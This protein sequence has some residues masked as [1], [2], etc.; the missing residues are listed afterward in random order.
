[1]LSFVLCGKSG[2]GKTQCIKIA[3]GKQ[4]SDEYTPTSTCMHYYVPTSG[5][6]IKEIPGDIPVGDD[7]ALYL[8][9]TRHVFIMGDE[10]CIDDR[11]YVNVCRIVN[12]DYTFVRTNAD[13]ISEIVK[14]MR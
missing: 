10:N 14:V 3:M 12:V 2:I 7:F 11:C 1:M 8:M 9:L 4:I 6:I 13:I 5:Y